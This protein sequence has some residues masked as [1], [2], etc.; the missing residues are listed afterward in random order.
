[1]EHHSKIRVLVVEDDED[2]YILTTSLLS[3]IYSTGVAP[4]WVRTYEEAI[5]RIGSD[6]YDVCLLDYRLGP[7]DGLDVLREARERGVD[8]PLILLTGQGDIEVD[9]QAMKAGAS[10]YLVKGQT[11][12][13]DLERS[14]RYAIQQRQI[15][16]ERIRHVLEREARTQAE[17]ANKAKDDFLAM[18]SHELR[19]PLNAMLGWVTILRN[20]PD[21]RVIRERA[22]DAIE[23]SAR[24]QNKLVN[25]LLDISRVTSGN[26][27]I[28]KQPVPLASVMESA[29]DEAFPAMKAKSIKLTLDIDHN[30]G[31]VEGDMHRLL[32]VLNNLLQNAVKF[33]PE[34]GRLTVSLE[35]HGPTAKI[36]VADNGVGIEPEFLPHV[37]DRYRQSR[38]MSERREGLGLGLAIARHI[39]EMHGGT[40]AVDS[41]GK[42]RGAVFT[43]TLP[44]LIEA[45][46]AQ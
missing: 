44:L 26:L 16:R 13:A 25:D 7:H 27:W 30:A 35:R 8:A 23:R 40:I 37:F 4:Q 9:L 28:E 19:A 29:I 21:D 15:A 39:V 5:E 2:D 14:I 32:Q 3:E 38:G 11:T 1:M 6:D 20:S 12:A 41:A 33:T 45:A 36:S 34:G 17:A 43:V 46:A 42:G 10:D 31:V 22:I 18:V 24:S